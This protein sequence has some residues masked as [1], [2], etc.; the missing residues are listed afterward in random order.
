M[1]EIEF[2]V[3]DKPPRKSQWGKEGKLIIKLRQ[4][5]LEAR[6]NAGMNE[7]YKGPVKLELTIFAPNIND[8]NYRQTGDDDPEK[9]VGDVDSFIAGVCDYLHKGPIPG[10]NKFEPDP[11]FL[12]HAEVG[13][14]DH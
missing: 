12:E 6:K 3:D 10:E 13:P 7:C 9:F 5:A 14:Q 11:L 2:D 1:T 8:L 4:T